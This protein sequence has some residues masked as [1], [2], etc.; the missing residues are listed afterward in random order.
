[1][2]ASA[3]LA[4]FAASKRVIAGVRSTITR[5]CYRTSRGKAHAAPLSAQ[6]PPPKGQKRISKQERKVMIEEFVD[7]Y[8]ASNEGKFPTITCVRQQIGG[9]H[10]TVR[11]ILQELEYNHANPPLDNATPVQ[12][13]GTT[14][15][16]KHSRSTDVSKEAQVQGSA[17]FA[18]HSWTKDDNGKN[19]DNSEAFKNGG[20]DDVLASMEDATADT[21]ATEKTETQGSMGSSDYIVETEAAKSDFIVSDSIKNADDATFSNQTE[22]DSLKDLPVVETEVAKSDFKVSG[23]IKNADDP[24]LSDQ[25]GSGGMKDLTN[26]PAV[27]SGMEAKSNLGKREDETEVN[28]L[29]FNNTANSLDGSKSTVSDQTGSDEVLQ[30]NIPDSGDGPK[31]EN[32]GSTETG[33]LGSLKSFAYGIKNFWKSL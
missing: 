9:G 29:D 1:M 28:K 10:Y 12:G 20:Q 15:F 27:P 13:Q 11:E 31:H 7:K 22:S 24:T 6:E 2:Q 5:S 4:S 21:T 19:P 17:Q 16:S 26:K 25:T 3:R 30:R 14:E 33:L 8:R 23:S 32:K 18:E